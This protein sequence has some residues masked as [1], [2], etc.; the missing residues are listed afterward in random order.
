MLTSGMLSQD[1]YKTG[2]IPLTGVL[3]ADRQLL[4]ARDELV[5]NQAEAARAAV[6]SFRA[7]GGGW[8]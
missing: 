4:I 8:S 1:A 2:D 6:R 7:L 3:D 5:S